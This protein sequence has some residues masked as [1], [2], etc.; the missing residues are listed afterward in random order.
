MPN[1]PALQMTLECR[2]V[3]QGD[4]AC[5]HEVACATWRQSFHTA[6]GLLQLIASDGYRRNGGQLHGMIFP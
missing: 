4:S 5:I 3:C 6:P 2:G 1:G